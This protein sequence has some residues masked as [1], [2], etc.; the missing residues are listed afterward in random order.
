MQIIHLFAGYSRVEEKLE[1]LGIRMKSISEK[2]RRMSS[3][4]E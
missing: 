4:I 1:K 2:V 3:E